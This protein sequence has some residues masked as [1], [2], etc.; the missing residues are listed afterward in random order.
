MVDKDEVLSQKQYNLAKFIFK[1]EK[2]FQR[3]IENIHEAIFLCEDDGK[4]QFLNNP[5]ERLTGFTV[6][7]S[8]GH[9]ISDFLH[10]DDK[11]KILDLISSEAKHCE[12]RFLHQKGHTIWFELSVCNGYDNK[13]IGL[14]YNI[15]ARKQIEEEVENERKKFYA[16]LDGLPAFVYLISEDFKITYCNR[17]FKN[18]FEDGT[19]KFCYDVINCNKTEHGDCHLSTVFK[20]KASKIWEWTDTRT[21][22]HYQIYD[23]PFIGVDGSALCLKMGI[24]ITKQKKTEKGHKK[25]IQSLEK[26]ISTIKA[27]RGLIPIC[28]KCKKIRD[29]KGFWNEVEH[30]ISD[31]SDA[32]FTHSICPGCTEE[33]YPDLYK[34]LKLNE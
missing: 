16:I 18:I 13:K 23:Y 27:L 34:K 8:L 9:F 17:L 19:G 15:T 29:D 28:A 6:K 33:L 14:L 20:T 2:H 31:H 10:K 22:Q 1:S 3:L 24:E 25:L 26:A 11:G 32:E 5:W 30:Y 7:E 21:E 4:L 12:L